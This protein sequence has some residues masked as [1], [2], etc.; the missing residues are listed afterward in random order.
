[1]VPKQISDKNAWKKNHMHIANAATSS[2]GSR[3]YSPGN[4]NK[5]INNIYTI[6]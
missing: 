5:D 6:S 3:V 4:I 1:M 2:H